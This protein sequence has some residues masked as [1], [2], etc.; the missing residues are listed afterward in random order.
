[1]TEAKGSANSR[2]FALVK[3]V[4]VETEGEKFEIVVRMRVEHQQKFVHHFLISLVDDNQLRFE[5]GNLELE[6]IIVRRKK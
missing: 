4:K 6:M 5:G 2:F 3:L 1:M